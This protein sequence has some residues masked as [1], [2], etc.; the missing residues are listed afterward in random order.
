MGE[1]GGVVGVDN[2]DTGVGEGPGSGGVLGGCGVTGSSVGR[3]HASKPPL[4]LTSNAPNDMVPSSMPSG[5]PSPSRYG[6]RPLPL[7]E[8]NRPVRGP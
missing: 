4:M 6:F 7:G 3:L 8:R 5:S 1:G 2:G